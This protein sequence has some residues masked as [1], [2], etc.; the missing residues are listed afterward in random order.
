MGHQIPRDA[1]EEAGLYPSDHYP[2]LA[3]LSISE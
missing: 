1:D 2:V 3:D